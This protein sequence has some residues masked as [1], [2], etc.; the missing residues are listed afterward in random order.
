VQGESVKIGIKKSSSYVCRV[1]A[2][3]FRDKL[4][5]QIHIIQLYVKMINKLTAIFQQANSILSPTLQNLQIQIYH[6]KYIAL[7]R[8]VRCT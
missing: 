5:P 6:K 3:H 1:Y 4:Y 8:T 7:K 2:K